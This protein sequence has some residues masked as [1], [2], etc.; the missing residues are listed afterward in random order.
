MLVRDETVEELRRTYKEELGG[1]ATV[2]EA[3]EMV[4]RLVFLYER[5]MRPLPSEP[6]SEENGEVAT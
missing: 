1:R 4:Q 2:A 5:L 3:R 6:N